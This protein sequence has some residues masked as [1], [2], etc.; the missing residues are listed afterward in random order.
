ME[1]LNVLKTYKLFID[2]KFVRSESGKVLALR[3][4][5]ENLIANY[6]EASRKDVKAAV[7]AARNALAGWSARTAYNRSQILYRMAEMLE[8]RSAV[9]IQELQAQGLTASQAKTEVQ[10]SVDRLVYYAGWCDKYSA[11][12]S[13]VNPVAS[14]HHT[15]S[16]PEPMGLVVVFCPANSALLGLISLMAPILA[17]GNTCVVMGSEKMP[18]SALSFGE[19]LA[20][21]DLPPGVV[22]IL[23]GNHLALYHEVSLHRDI[24][25]LQT[26]ELAG[27]TEK[28][29]AKNC[30][31]NLKRLNIY[32]EDWRQATAQGP[33]YILDTQELKTTWHAAETIAGGGVK[34]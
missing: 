23:S 19:V 33:Y 7:V 17:G 10:A 30:A 1:R 20:T 25:A 12:F 8:S 31:S 21:S 11:V 2:G 27:E 24:N 32:K 13:S 14:S 28:M 6:S 18:L 26:G 5:K 34:Y 22:N 15:F 9:F 3:S 29:L 16:V 4:N